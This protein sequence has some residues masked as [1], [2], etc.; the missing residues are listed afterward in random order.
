MAQNAFAQNQVVERW[1]GN[2]FFEFE[3]KEN[4][5]LAVGFV[6]IVN[7]MIVTIDSMEKALAVKENDK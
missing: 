6:E 4:G 7:R 3:R 1:T 5:M 2:Y